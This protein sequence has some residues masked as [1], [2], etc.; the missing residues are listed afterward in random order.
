MP[1]QSYSKPW[2]EEKGKTPLQD[3]QTQVRVANTQ[4]LVRKVLRNLNDI[5]ELEFWKRSYPNLTKHN[6]VFFFFFLET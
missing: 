3:I 4:E 6:R 5:S 1:C 2:E